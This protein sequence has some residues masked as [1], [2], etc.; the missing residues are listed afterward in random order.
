MNFENDFVDGLV[1]ASLICAYAPYL[2]GLVYIQSSLQCYKC[3]CNII[4][5]LNFWSFYFQQVTSELSDLYTQ[6]NSAEQ[7]LHNALKVVNALRKLGLDYDILAT[8]ITE[9]N[10]VSILLLCV[11][12]YQRL[13]FYLPTKTVEFTGSLFS[14]VTKQVSKN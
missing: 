4:N 14:T 1:L 11:Y 9:P 3:L 2:V 5:K 7:C 13:P 12:L 8:D 10:A 6:P